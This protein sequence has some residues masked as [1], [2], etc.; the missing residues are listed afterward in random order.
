MARVMPS[1]TIIPTACAA[2]RSAVF[3]LPPAFTRSVNLTRFGGSS[4]EREFCL[5][6]HDLL[7]G[8]LRHSLLPGGIAD[9][10]TVAAGI[11]KIELPPGEIALGAVFQLDDGNPVVVKGL[12][13]LHETFGAYGERMMHALFDGGFVLQLLPLA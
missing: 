11:M 8:R 9:L 13:G 7:V 1:R 2:R 12:A 3:K 5:G 4:L 6:L 10:E